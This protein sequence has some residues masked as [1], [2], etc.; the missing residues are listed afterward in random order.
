M[1]TRRRPRHA[2]LTGH[3]DF[4]LFLLGYAASK[5]GSQVTLLALP[6]AAALQLDASAFDLG[7]LTVVETAA[8]LIAGLPAGAWVDKVRRLPVLVQADLLRFA[9]I[10]SLPVAACM[11]RLTLAHLYLAAAVTGAATV[12]S[13]IASQSFLPGLLPRDRLI[14]GNGAVATVQSSA[15][16]VGPGIGGG[17]VQAMGAPLALVADAIS[18]LVSAVLLLGIRFREA[19]PAPTADRTFGKDILKGVGF[20]LGHPELRAIAVTTGTSN[21]FT[22]FLFSVQTAFWTRDLALSPLEIGLVLSASAVGGLAGALLAGR[23]ARRVGQVRLILLSVT[24]TSPFALLWPLSAGP[25]APYTFATGLAVVWSG[26]VTYNVAQL[27]FRQLVCPTELLG[28]MN[29]TMRFLA[30]GVMPLGA[31]AGGAL[32]S[33]WGPRAALWVCAAGFLCLPLLVLSSPLRKRTTG[34]ADVAGPVT[35]D[36]DH[37][38]ARST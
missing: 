12:L 27:T 38:K 20:V 15:E 7:L 37:G 17:L 34:P 6:L 10:G 13:D 21:L 2:P 29:A 31:L 26:A 36:P 3:R 1:N 9:V 19:A 8:M 25:S 16:V 35:G 22:A 11:D 18:Y 24:V 30:L 32:A 14:A 28:R 33:G 23:M 5:T 4:R